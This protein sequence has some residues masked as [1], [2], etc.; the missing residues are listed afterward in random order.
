MHTLRMMTHIPFTDSTVLPTP[1]ESLAAAATAINATASTKGLHTSSTE[2]PLMECPSGQNEDAL[3]T[4]DT[5]RKSREALTTNFAASTLDEFPSLGAPSLLRPTVDATENVTSSVWT[6]GTDGFKRSPN[7]VLPST[8]PSI[9]PSQMTEARMA[10]HQKSTAYNTRPEVS[11]RSTTPLLKSDEPL[12]MGLKVED[13]AAISS[14]RFTTDSLKNNT[15]SNNTAI[16][17]S[18]ARRS[19]SV[20]NT[21]IS[22]APL[23]NT[24]RKIPDDVFVV[25]DDFLQ[26]NFKRAASIYEKKKACKGCEIRSKLKY[27]IWSDIKKQWQ[28]IRPYPAEKV[29][30]NVAFSQCRQYPLN[31]SCLRTPCSFA[32]GEQ[33]LQ[34]WTLEREGGMFNKLLV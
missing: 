30:P 1:Q 15:S 29:P 7:Q 31:T 19:S 8:K 11:G 34:M 24:F 3:Q 6:S 25:C 28:I 5:R 33:E 22:T 26:K 16:P 10:S 18:E 23:P 20:S 27:A 32:H 13:V 17:I 12:N 14:Q 21:K 2:V 4:T 9:L